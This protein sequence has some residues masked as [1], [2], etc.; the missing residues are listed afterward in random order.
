M[1]QHDDSIAPSLGGSRPKRGPPPRRTCSTVHCAPPAG[2][3]HA[4]GYLPGSA[5]IG[6][7][8]ALRVQVAR[9][10]GE[11]ACEHRRR[12]SCCCSPSPSSPE[13]SW[14]GRACS[15]RRR[16]I[17]ASSPRSPAGSSTATSWHL[18]RRPGR[19]GDRGRVQ[20][21]SEAGIP[22]GWSSDGTRLLIMRER[23]S[24]R[25]PVRPAR[26]R[27][28][29]AGDRA[30]DGRSLAR[31]ISPDGSRV[32]F[33]G[34]TRRRTGML[35]G[36]V[37]GR[38]RGRPRRC[39]S[40]SSSGTCGIRLRPGRDADRVHR[41]R[42]DHSH[43]VWLMNADGSDAHQILANE[44]TDGRRSR[45][46]PR[47]VAGGRSDRA[48]ARGDHLHLRYRRLGFTQMIAD[49]D[50]PYWSPDGSQIAYTLACPE[51][52]D[53]CGLAIADAD[54]SNVRT[55]DFGTSGPWHPAP[56]PPNAVTHF[57]RA[58]STRPPSPDMA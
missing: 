25:A 45:L 8:M 23:R 7:A 4:H 56:I 54:G 21:T 27:V 33:S 17:S 52:P 10:S 19:A 58:R 2:A 18:G 5:V 1:S 11:R 47:L 44:T 30:A 46:R 53:G 49:G 34:G 42:G 20:L 48:R 26:R 35:I 14:S 9:C 40:S 31:T 3:D 57:P 32:V 15:S 16:S 41:R 51:C 24:R 29:D 12:W 50:R 36:A 22:L 6:S 37:R 39:S 43:R 13:G 38:R 55:F 28:R